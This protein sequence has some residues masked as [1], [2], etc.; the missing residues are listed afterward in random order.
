MRQ[1]EVAPATPPQV[2]LAAPGNG[3]R[4]PKAATFFNKGQTFKDEI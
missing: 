4:L 1:A 2:H 3:P